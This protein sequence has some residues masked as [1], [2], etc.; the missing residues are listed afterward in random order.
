MGSPHGKGALALPVR[1]SSQV[2][3]V[4]MRLLQ[5]VSKGGVAV[6]LLTEY[7]KV[8]CVVAVRA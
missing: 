7:S 5:P 8:Q 6:V 1:T 3:D 2:D 4:I